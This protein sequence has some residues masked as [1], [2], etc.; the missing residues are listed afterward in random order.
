MSLTNKHFILT[1]HIQTNAIH[2]Y[3]V[4]LDL[5]VDLELHFAQ[6]DQEAQNHQRLK[7]QGQG[8]RGDQED[9][10]GRANRALPINH[11][12][13]TKWKTFNGKFENYRW[14]VN[15]IATFWFLTSKV[16]GQ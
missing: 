10:V 11:F 14:N 16:W 7:M 5:P 3:H 4:S 12:K 6:E 13:E 15:K 8:D 9:Q 2:M 1:Q